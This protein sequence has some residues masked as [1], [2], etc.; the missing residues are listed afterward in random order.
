MKPLNSCIVIVLCC[1]TFKVLYCYT[2]I[3][4]L[5][6]CCAYTVGLGVKTGY[7]SFGVTVQE[8]DSATVE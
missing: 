4:K 7:N 1:H 5:L 6:N 3:P 8:Y 2:V